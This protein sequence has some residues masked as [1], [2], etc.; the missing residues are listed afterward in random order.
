M[1]FKHKAIDQAKF[2]GLERPNYL[3]KIIPHVDAGP[4]PLSYRYRLRTSSQALGQ[5][6]NA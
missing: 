5:P 6:G 2:A 4:Y 1:G 3:L